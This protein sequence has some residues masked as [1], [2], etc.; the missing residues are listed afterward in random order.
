MADSS[1]DN[2]HFVD[3]SFSRQLRDYNPCHCL[4]CHCEKEVVWRAT[5]L[6]TET[7]T[8]VL[9]VGVACARG[10]EERQGDRETEKESESVGD[11]KKFKTH[12]AFQQ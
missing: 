6:R 2:K 4:G 12:S 5:D 8:R 11:R 7:R 3:T 10:R 1:R 9:R